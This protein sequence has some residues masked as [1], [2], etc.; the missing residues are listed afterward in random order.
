[1][2]SE[3]IVLK[4]FWAKN[5]DSIVRFKKMRVERIPNFEKQIRY[6]RQLLRSQNF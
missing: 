4:G 1:M 3:P 5:E 2:P 6:V